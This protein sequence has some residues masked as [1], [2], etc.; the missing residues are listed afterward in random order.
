MRR[1][2]GGYLSSAAYRAGTREDDILPYD[3]TGYLTRGHYPSDTAMFFYFLI[4][5]HT[6]SETKP[7]CSFAFSALSSLTPA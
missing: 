4:F 1:G 3:G 2:T 6:A 5:A 7:I